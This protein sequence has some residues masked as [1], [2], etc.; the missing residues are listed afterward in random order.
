MMNDDGYYDYYDARNYQNYSHI[1]LQD[2]GY[3]TL[4]ELNIGGNAHHF[5]CT[6]YYHYYR[7]P[8]LHRRPCDIR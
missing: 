2:N 5:Y 1:V 4:S 8:V 3:N 7:K 6:N